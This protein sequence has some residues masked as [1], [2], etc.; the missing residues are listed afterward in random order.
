MVQTPHMWK[1][2][3]C[4]NFSEQLCKDIS[5]LFRLFLDVTASIGFTLRCFILV[6]LYEV[7]TGHN[8]GL[9]A[10]KPRP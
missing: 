10:V 3:V 5:A 9:V 1:N 7:A 8:C 6:V 2:E 4:L